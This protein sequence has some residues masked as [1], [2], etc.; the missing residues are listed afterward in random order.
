MTSSR[1]SANT[2]AERLPPPETDV[3]FGPLRAGAVGFL[4]KNT[5]AKDLLEAVR[6]VARG[7]GLSAPVVTVG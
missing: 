4:L 6:A 2:F 5:E 3:L 7:E 1:R